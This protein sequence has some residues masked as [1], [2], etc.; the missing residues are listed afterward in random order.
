MSPPSRIQIEA[1]EH[2]SEYSQHPLAPTAHALS[3]MIIIELH[4][5]IIYQISHYI[6]LP[7]FL[8]G[9]IAQI[10]PFQLD[11]HS[12]SCNTS[13]KHQAVVYCVVRMWQ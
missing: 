11:H 12:W 7:Y 4:H 5:S 8:F 13:V 10:L 1:C 3:K 6:A 2:Q 9:L